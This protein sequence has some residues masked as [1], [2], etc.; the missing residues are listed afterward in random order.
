MKCW[1]Q[2]LFQRS[3]SATTHPTPA[4][5]YV[6]GP[7]ISHLHAGV[8]ALA[9]GLICR[10]VRAGGVQVAKN[11]SEFFAMRALLAYRPLGE[12]ATARGP[13]G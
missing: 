8:R 6:F 10:S 9:P 11:F 4:H 3:S 5:T 7:I 13:R 1:G 2:E 12:P